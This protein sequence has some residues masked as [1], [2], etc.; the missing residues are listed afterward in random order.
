MSKETHYHIGM[1]LFSEDRLEEAIAELKQALDQDQDYG[2]ALH[3]LA[4]SYYHLGDIDKALEFG[5]RLR[6]AEP[7]NVHAYT[8]L[9]MFYNAK[10]F[11]AKAEEMGE[12]AAR[13]AQQEN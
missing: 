6:V 11:I 5:E 1:E 13:L 2:D 8:S 10:G 7:D 12:K 9:S 3:A 4:M